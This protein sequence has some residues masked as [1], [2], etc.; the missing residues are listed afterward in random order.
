M[1]FAFTSSAPAAAL[2]LPVRNG[3]ISTVVPSASSSKAAWPS[4][5]M[6]IARTCLSVRRRRWS[7]NGAL[8]WG[9]LLSCVGGVHQLLRELEPD[10]DADQHPEP[11]LL[12]DKRAH[13]AQALLGVLGERGGRHLALVGRAEPAALGER[14]GQHP[15]QSGRGVGDDLRGMAEARGVA[16]RLDG[17]VDLLRGEPA[18]GHQEDP[19][20]SGRPA[21]TAA[22]RPDSCAQPPR[23]STAMSETSVGV[24]P[25]RTPLAS[26]ASAFACAVPAL[27][28]T[29][30]PA[31]PMVLPAGAVKAAM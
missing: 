8:S 23:I 4:Q 29:I 14:L 27:P 15:L 10:R 3:S 31:W 28:D 1:A 11:G 2:G 26:S 18:A 16:Q 20:P 30:A 7:S 19:N 21:A 5:R 22:G 17:R 24:R 6:F 13:G 9:R 25:T 12:G